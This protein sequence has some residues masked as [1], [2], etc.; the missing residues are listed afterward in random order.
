[1]KLATT[2]L[3]ECSP[4]TPAVAGFG[5]SFPTFFLLWHALCFAAHWSW[6]R[7]RGFAQLTF[8][9]ALAMVS[10]YGWWEYSIGVQRESVAAIQRIGGIVYY[11]SQWQN[12][13]P[14]FGARKSRL[15]ERI[16]NLLGPDFF[17]TVV[18]VHLS[19]RGR[20]VTED[21]MIH[22]GRLRNLQFLALDDPQLTSEGLAPLRD[23]TRLKAIY[24][25]NSSFCPDLSV[26]EK[27]VELEDLLV[28]E[29]RCSDAELAHLAGL[30]K[31]KSLNLS[32]QRITSA[33]L[34]HLA[35]M[36]N[37]ETLTLHHTSITSLDPIRGLT[38]LKHL[39]VIGSPIDDAGLAPAAAFKKM[40][41]LYLA[42]T[43]VTDDG[44]APLAGLRSLKLLDLSETPVGD[45]GLRILCGLPSII[46]LQLGG[47]NVTDTGLASVIEKLNGGPCQ[48]LEISRTKVT[49]A[50]LDSARA[51]LT[52]TQIWGAPAFFS[53]NRP[54]TLD[55][56]GI[57]VD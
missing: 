47:T 34:A 10:L 48:N 41:M 12:G 36:R 7:R 30:T 39:D 44:L 15:P 38:G 2:T 17:E 6:H 31:L 35:A 9:C 22:V 32:D 1:M 50:G 23:L 20:R 42:Q 45:A 4:H 18:A 40:E 14:V 27:M 43:K 24:F 21:V 3:P 33:G 57:S 54:R 8:I 16:V 28:P 11:E 52:H 53:N 56:A 49:R 51:K 46:H 26:F 5:R 19:R 55:P 13:Q 25:M 37:M 29:I